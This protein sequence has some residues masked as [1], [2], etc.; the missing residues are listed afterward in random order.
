VLGKWV[1]AD[2]RKEYLAVFPGVR[3]RYWRDRGIGHSIEKHG[4]GADPAY[5]SNLAEVHDLGKG[6]TL[7][8]LEEING[9][10]V[11]VM[12]AERS[13][14]ARRP[15]NWGATCSISDVQSLSASEP[16]SHNRGVPR[17]PGSIFAQGAFSTL[18]S[19]LSPRDSWRSQ[20]PLGD[21]EI[22]RWLACPASPL[23]FFSH[24]S[25]SV[26]TTSS[27]QPYRGAPNAKADF[28]LLFFYCA[29]SGNSVELLKHQST[30]GHRQPAL[31]VEAARDFSIR[32]PP[33]SEV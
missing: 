9:R 25:A 16:A 26:S 10:M 4:A 21:R 15:A 32:W 3:D 27:Y 18:R 14:P 24:F 17:K 28:S 7:E 2:A 1:R 6:F 13:Q 8:E 23:L 19:Q 12:Q 5:R 30:D 20:G 22:A 33:T 11:A 31:A 29:R